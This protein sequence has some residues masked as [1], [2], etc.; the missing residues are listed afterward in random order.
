MGISREH[1]EVDITRNRTDGVTIYYDIYEPKNGVIVGHGFT[2]S[3]ESM[4]LTSLALAVS[5]FVVVSLDFGH[6][7]SGGS[8]ATG[9]RDNTEE[10]TRDILANKYLIR[11]RHHF[12]LASKLVKDSDDFLKEN[13][14]DPHRSTHLDTLSTEID[15]ETYHLYFNRKLQ[16]IG[17]KNLQKFSNHP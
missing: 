13:S 6:G 1:S 5:G 4:H 16:T 9:S 7:R 10:L 2:A 17:I 12:R 14:V 11:A 3:K 15:D 8:L